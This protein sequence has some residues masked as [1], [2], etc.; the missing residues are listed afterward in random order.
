MLLVIDVGNT[1]ITLG[2]FNKKE[3]VGTFRLTTRQN[4]TSDEYGIFMCDVLK[5]QGIN[6]D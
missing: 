3:L 1:H 2:V 5:Y 6:K 4:R